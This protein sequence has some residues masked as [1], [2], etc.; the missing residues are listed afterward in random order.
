MVRFTLKQ[1]AYF[2]AVVEHGGI[3]QAARSLNISQPA[4][5]QALDKLEEQYGFRLL[6]R[7]H[8]RGTELT[9]EG[10]A[11]AGSCQALMET[12]ESVERKARSIAAQ[13]A[14]IIRFGCFH[15]IAPF[16]LARIV[17]A[18]RADHPQVDIVPSELM[19]E[20]VISRLDTD[21]LDLALTYDM[22]L[23]GKR[24][25]WIEVARLSPVVLLASSHPMAGKSSVDLADL[26]DEP[27]V[28]FDGASS[29]EYFQSVLKEGRIDPPV[30]FNSSSM[31]SARCA[32]ANGMGFSL[33]VMRPGHS[34]TY[35]GGTVAAVP[36]RGNSVPISLVLASK[37]H[38]SPSGLIDSFEEFC[39]SVCRRSEQQ[40]D[41]S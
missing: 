17:N 18:Y 26:A 9:P 3:A 31:E 20:D 32:V 14:G 21:R 4:V 38:R 19:Q 23:D 13:R 22:G 25:D 29:R 16:Y 12:A 33:T 10:R 35:D 41:P 11:F 6:H 28:M 1:C 15:T 8:A 37:K 7:H 40:A 34:A 36:I 30:A 5:P 39:L 2:L 27:F 24:L